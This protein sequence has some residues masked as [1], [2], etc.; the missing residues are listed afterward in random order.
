[1]LLSKDS[2]IPGC[3]TVSLGESLVTFS[4]IIELSLTGIKSFQKNAFSLG[5]I[6]HFFQN[7]R[8]H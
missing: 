6:P 5:K 8:D 2:G 4:R 1:M 3:D 7:I